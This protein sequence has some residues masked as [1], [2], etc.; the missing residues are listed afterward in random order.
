MTSSKYFQ[1]VGKLRGFTARRVLIPVQSGH[2]E[3]VNLP[4][5]E[6]ALSTL[7]ASWWTELRRDST[8]GFCVRSTARKRRESGF[9]PAFM[10][11]ST[12]EISISF[13]LVEHH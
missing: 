2:F 9:P 3:F 12:P 13:E 10:S 6:I 11:L 7:I 4:H 8:E 5:S 1:S